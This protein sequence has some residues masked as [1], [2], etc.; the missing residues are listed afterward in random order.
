M[1]IPD[2]EPERLR[3]GDTWRWQRELAD[4]PATTWTLRYRFK[5]SSGGFEISASA[6][7]VLHD[8]T[9]SAA[10]TAAYAAGAYSWAAWVESAGEVYTVDQGRLT[11]DPNLRAGL[12]SVGL[13]V[14]SHARRTL[15]ALEA[16]IE[17][18]ASM[19]QSEYRIGDRMLKR[20]SID[21]LLKFRDR[22]RSEVEAEDAA[23]RLLNGRTPGYALQ[24][25]L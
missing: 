25:R 21:E 2:N 24:V 23:D 18:R 17:G 15:E 12:A 7:G 5:N 10:T 4:Y 22:Y 19:D 9:V 6:S 8:V 3:A 11:V 16:V 20:M 14:R 13:D 1:N